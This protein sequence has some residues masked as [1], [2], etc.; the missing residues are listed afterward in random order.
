MRGFH[1]HPNLEEIAFQH[2]HFLAAPA[3][4][5]RLHV[6]VPHCTIKHV[7]TFAMRDFGIEPVRDDWEEA[8]DEADVVLRESMGE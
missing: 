1:R 6:A 8:V 5:Q 7:L 2:D 3:E 4:L